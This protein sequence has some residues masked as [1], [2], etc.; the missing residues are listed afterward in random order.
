MWN[1]LHIARQA[2]HYDKQGD[3]LIK[4]QATMAI[5]RIVEHCTAVYWCECECRQRKETQ[6]ENETKARMVFRKSSLDKRLQPRFCLSLQAHTVVRQAT[7]LA[8]VDRAS[9]YLFIWAT[10]N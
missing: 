6:N 9:N 2:A 8:H 4:R 10:A 3:N 7:K 5:R 1:A